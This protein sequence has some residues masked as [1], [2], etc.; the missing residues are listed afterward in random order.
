VRL[1]ADPIKID[2]PP[3]GLEEEASEGPTPHAD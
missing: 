1:W 2:A 3:R